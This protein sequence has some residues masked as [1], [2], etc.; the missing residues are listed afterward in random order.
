MWPVG[1][2]PTTY[3]LK[4]C[5]STNWAKITKEHFLVRHKPRARVLYQV[6]SRCQ[7]PKNPISLPLPEYIGLG[8]L[9]QSG[10][11]QSALPISDPLLLHS[12]LQTHDEHAELLFSSQ[13]YSK[14]SHMDFNTNKHPVLFNDSSSFGRNPPFQIQ[15]KRSDMWFFSSVISSSFFSGKFNKKTISCHFLFGSIVLPFLFTVKI[16]S[17]KFFVR[18]FCRK[19]LRAYFELFAWPLQH[20]LHSVSG[21]V[22]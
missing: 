7:Q 5:C 17:R 8:Q 21:S 11:Q 12:W 6:L 1:V 13:P 2:E 20:P 4:V 19:W 10:H 9:Q 15:P 16:K 22:L 3:R 14:S 18:C